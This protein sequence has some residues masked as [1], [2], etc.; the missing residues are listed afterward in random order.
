MRLMLS[1]THRAAG[2]ARCEVHA[3]TLRDEPAEW[4]VAPCGAAVDRPHA[5]A[6]EVTDF[7]GVPCTPC[8][9]AFLATLAHTPGPAERSTPGERFPTE[10]SGQYAVGL[11]GERE[12]HLVGIDALCSELDGR[13][14]V[15]TVCARLA[16]GPLDRAPESWPLCAECGHVAAAGTVD[17]PVVAPGHARRTPLPHSP[18][19]HW[20]ACGYQ[21]HVFPTCAMDRADGKLAAFC[22]ILTHELSEQDGRN[23]CTWCVDLVR[24][25][26]VQIIPS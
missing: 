25:G 2:V 4:V 14:V 18:T 20:A 21:N 1:R 12:R 22:G 13:S 6:C 15:H 19:G 17:V 5:E 7:D 3:Y 10:P 26:R 23:V 9:L 24:T 16:W 8:L 11:R